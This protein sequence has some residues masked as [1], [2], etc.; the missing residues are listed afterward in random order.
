MALLLTWEVD[1]NGFFFSCDYEGSLISPEEWALHEVLL[2]NGER[3]GLGKILS[4]LEDEK[5]EIVGE[6]VS[7]PHGAIAK[8][9]PN[10]LRSVG[11]PEP[12]PFSLYIE[13][14]GLLTDKEFSF[15]YRFI[16]PDLRPVMGAQRTGA[17]L[18]VGERRHIIPDPFFAL[19]SGMD[20]YN[21]TQPGDIEGRL[22][23]WGTLKELLPEDAVLG[24]Y[25]KTLR[26]VKADAFTLN[27]FINS[28]GEPDF[29][30]ILMR[31]LHSTEGNLG[32]VESSLDLENALP[33]APQDAFADQFR[34]FHDAHKRYALRGGW[35]LVL[36][37]SLEKA[38]S[39]CS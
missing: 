7:V 21:S 5:A 16:H 20:A 15:S 39:G 12:M 34:T 37:P 25:L 29:D 32:S 22:L 13:G 8:I 6:T 28:E 31:S 36:P 27:P 1:E 23:A 35:Y 3:A 24:D 14:Q 38:M 4:L 17:L 11:L 30:P 26:V 33:K 19:I 9:S 10:D 18:K 2:Q